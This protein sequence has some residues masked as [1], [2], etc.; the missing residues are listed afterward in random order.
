MKEKTKELLD[1]KI[2]DLN[3]FV[4]DVFLEQVEGQ[5]KLNIVL[6][7]AEVIDLNKITDASRIIN[8]V[9]DNNKITNEEYDELDVYS[10]TKGDIK[11][12]E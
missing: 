10:K 12:N 7:S 2:S 8:K 11:A 3:L 9:I 6:D 4:D 5:T 1:E